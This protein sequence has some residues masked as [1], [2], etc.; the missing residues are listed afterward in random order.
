M[1]IVCFI[2]YCLCKLASHV[3][4]ATHDCNER[5]EKNCIFYIFNFGN[6]HLYL[7]EVRTCCKK[8]PF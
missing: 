5:G 8:Y 6:F 2:L 3:I 1:D 7:V 4:V